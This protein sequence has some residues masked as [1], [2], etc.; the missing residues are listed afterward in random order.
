MAFARKDSMEVHRKTHLKDK[1]FSCEKCKRS[2]TRK[3]TLNSHSKRCFV[4][5]QISSA[6][7]E[8]LK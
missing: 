3:N 4:E 2:F 8:S 6:L 5:T 7:D 1:E